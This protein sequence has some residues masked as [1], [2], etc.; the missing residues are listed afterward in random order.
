[1]ASLILD[2]FLTNRTTTRSPKPGIPL[3]YVLSNRSK[4]EVLP[5]TIRVIPGGMGLT[6]LAHLLTDP[7]VETIPGLDFDYVDSDE[8]FE[9]FVHHMLTH[10]H[11]PVDMIVAGSRG[12]EL[13]ARIL[14]EAPFTNCT[15]LLFGPIHLNR[16][17]PSSNNKIVIVHG[18]DDTNERIDSVRA[19]TQRHQPNVT[20]IEVDDNGHDLA[21]EETKPIRDI[22]NFVF[23][24]PITIG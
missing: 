23:S 9:Q 7:A 2:T 11:T 8:S 19:Y 5:R 12:A 17:V 3:R 4:H 20:L 1:M 14:A 21:F 16:I 10:E 24:Q 22:I 18:V 15:I 13:I 6:N